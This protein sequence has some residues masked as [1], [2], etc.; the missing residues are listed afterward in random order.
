MADTFI[1]GIEKV[2]RTLEKMSFESNNQRNIIRRVSR[3]GG[4]ILKDE[5]KRL[6]PNKETFEHVSEIRKQVKVITSKSKVRPGVNVYIDKKHEVP[7]GQGESRRWWK[8]KD[9][10]SLVFFG[11]FKTPDRRKKGSPNKGNVKGITGYNPYKLAT[12]NK[13]KKALIVMSNN[14]IKEIQKEYNKLRRR[15]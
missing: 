12:L 3:K 1:E 11:N 4:N 14:L 15:G 8:L 7:V 5:V 2:N 9:Y 13:G 6:I 10:Q